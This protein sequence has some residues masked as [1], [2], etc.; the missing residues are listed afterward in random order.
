MDSRSERCAVCGGQFGL[1]RYSR[2]IKD[3]GWKDVCSKKCLYKRIRRKRD[4]KT[5]VFESERDHR[6]AEQTG[7]ASFVHKP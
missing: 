4:D 7:D 1:A 5:R 6:E 2:L 3:Q